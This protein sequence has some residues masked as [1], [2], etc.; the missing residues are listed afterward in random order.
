MNT[1]V[2]V[3]V[4]RFECHVAATGYV[5][6]I[7]AVNGDPVFQYGGVIDRPRPLEV[8]IRNG[9]LIVIDGFADAEA[10]TVDDV[11]DANLMTWL[12][13][14]SRLGRLAEGGPLVA[15]IDEGVDVVVALV[16]VDDTATAKSYLTLRL[17]IREGVTFL[18]VDNAD[19]VLAPDAA[20]WRTHLDG[21]GGGIS[22]AR[23]GTVNQFR[24]GDAS[25]E[26]PINVTID[27]IDGGD[28]VL[29]TTGPIQL[30]P[31][32]PPP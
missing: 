28:V 3:E 19:A 5:Y 27:V 9:T 18:E 13:A 1:D 21:G 4:A 31:L 7:S 17:T 14:R 6:T 23:V 32:M 2:V 25:A 12:D 22:T 24:I 30:V 20:F 29:Q 26:D 11:I 8:G 10:P 16:P 15:T